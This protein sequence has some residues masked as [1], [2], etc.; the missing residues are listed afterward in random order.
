VWWRRVVY[1]LTVAASLYLVL[2]PLSRVV[3]RSAK[4]TTALHPISD[5]LGFLSVFLPNYG[6]P[7]FNDYQGD[8]LRFL[9]VATIIV[10]LMGWS[11]KLS[12]RIID[13]MAA[14]WHAPGGG[15][16]LPTS[17]VYRVRRTRGYQQALRALKRHIAPF[18]FAM[19]FI[20]LGVGALGHVVYLFGDSFGLFCRQ[21][22]DAKELPQGQRVEIPFTPSAFCLGTRVLLEDG[23]KYR[24]TIR[25]DQGKPWR[26]G[27]VE[28]TLAGFRIGELP[29]GK[30]LPFV[31]G[32]PLKR[33]LIRPWFR[34]ILRFGRIGTFEDYLAPAANKPPDDDTL[35]ET[36]TA[37]VSD[38]L[39]V[40]VNDIA[41]PL[42]RI[43]D[44][45]YRNNEGQA[46]IIVER[47]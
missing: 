27:S 5:A 17:V 47:L 14:I 30:R 22:P 3:P 45:F 20:W 16:G 36:F 23:A 24:V 37:R 2:Y 26:D 25:R 34:V 46:T 11:S 12:S 39:F 7:W 6:N 13:A 8:P 43:Y 40:S 21:S 28:T 41:L 15:D 1:F 9:I 10:V 4:D 33:E 32:W 35:E 44:L 19:L 18:V 42:P 38:E 31:V 29:I